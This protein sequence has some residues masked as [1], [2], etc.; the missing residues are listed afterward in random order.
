MDRSD[1]DMFW[2]YEDL[3]KGREI[4]EIENVEESD[5]QDEYITRNSSSD[6]Y[7]YNF[8]IKKDFNHRINKLSLKVL[9]FC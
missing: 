2:G 1:D 8:V 5:Q 9:F 6:L 3:E 4:I 7:R